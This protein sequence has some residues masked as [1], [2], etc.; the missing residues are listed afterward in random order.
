MKKKNIIVNEDERFNHSSFILIRPFS[1]FYDV[2][3]AYQILNENQLFMGVFYLKHILETNIKDIPV[4]FTYLDSNV[5]KNLFETIQEDCYNTSNR[6]TLVDCPHFM[7][8]L[9]LTIGNQYF[10]QLEPL[11]YKTFKPLT[12]LEIFNLYKNCEFRDSNLYP[13]IEAFIKTS[14][15]DKKLMVLTFSNSIPPETFQNKLN[16]YIYVTNFANKKTA[17][18]PTA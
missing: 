1:T 11:I 3:Q 7:D 18:K 16:Q 5:D 12:L 9:K 2:N 13:K 17:K 14:F 15:R 10:S 6:L 8:F 4:Q